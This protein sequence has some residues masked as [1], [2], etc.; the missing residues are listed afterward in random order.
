MLYLKQLYSTPTLLCFREPTPTFLSLSHILSP[1]SMS[2]HPWTSL[3]KAKVK[4]KL[5]AF[6]IICHQILH[7]H[8]CIW[9]N[10]S[11]I[12]NSAN[13]LWHMYCSEATLVPKALYMWLYSNKTWQMYW[14]HFRFSSSVT[15]KMITTNWDLYRFIYM[16]R[17]CYKVCGQK[18]LSPYQSIILWCWTDT[19]NLCHQIDSWKILSVSVWNW[20]ISSFW[21]VCSR[22]FT[23]LV[24][25]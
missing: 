9:I 6:K 24:K 17:H 14:L 13:C 15:V 23:K 4:S 25:V 3:I 21:S 12:H 20:S 19:S 11:I 7:I 18:G 22:R 2:L 5:L 10:K 8:M 1:L 16:T